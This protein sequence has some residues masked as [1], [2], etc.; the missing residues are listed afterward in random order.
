MPQSV[1]QLKAALKARGLPMTGEKPDLEQ[2]LSLHAAGEL[3]KLDGVN[4]ISLKA[5][6]LKK[7]LATRGLPCDL[8]IQSRDELVGLLLSALKQEASAAAGGSAGGHAKESSAMDE[9]VAL[10]KKVLSLGEAADCE[11]V[12]SVLGTAVTRQSSFG[13]MRKAYLNLAR[14]IHPDK[15]SRHFDGATRAFQ[16]LVRAFEEIS[17]P[18]PPP[19]A[20]GG[21]A[22]PK[23]KTLSRSNAGCHRTK[24]CCPRCRSVWGTADSGVQPYDYSFLMQGLKSYCCALCL[25]E[26]GCVSAIHLCPHCDR[27][28]E[29]HPQDYHRQ[30][31]CGRTTCTKPFGFMLYHVPP[32]VENDMR[33][34][35]KAE[36]ERR[37][38]Q[39]EAS[40]ARLQRAARKETP[41]SDDERRKHAEKLF[42]RSL[43]DDC[44]RCGYSPPPSADFEFLSAH[45]RECTDAAAHA[46]HRRELAAASAALSRRH[47]REEADAEA[48]N[49]AAWQF[50][51]G[52]TESMWLLT[53]KQL[54]K[55]C[56]EAGVKVGPSRDENLAALARRRM[57][58]DAARIEGGKGMP[59]LAYHPSAGGSDLGGDRKKR[60]KR[61]DDQPTASPAGRRIAVSAASLPS[62]I[63]SMSLRQLRS[64]C[65]AHGF[66][67]KGDTTEALIAE[68][69]QSLYEGTEDAPLLLD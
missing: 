35:I 64:V 61:S 27:P 65:A 42:V 40:A 14:V 50:L 28:F 54:R 7:A 59:S 30:L 63:H 17:A 20:A 1:A 29:Y 2:R 26:F 49:L 52:S 51:G 33:A 66:V 57:T 25:C 18:E 47:A 4:P 56:E 45:L 9:A 38:K 53:D 10:A 60:H 21:G 43:L 13:Q 24:V 68:L 44:P 6:E 16:M 34:E 55:Q 31:T 23:E 69:E 15:I 37:L 39:R 11:G 8:S 41:M 5:G 48:Q 46:R 58:T 62:N 22:K 12:L 3:H 32:R 67:P 36:Q 19:K